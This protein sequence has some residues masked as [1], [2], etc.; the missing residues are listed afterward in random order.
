APLP[1]K[2]AQVDVAKGSIVLSRESRDALDVRTAEVEVR[3]VPD[4]ISAYATLV[5]PWSRH[6][7]ASSRLPGQ[8]AAIHVQAGQQVTGGQVVAEV[9]SLE[10]ENLYLELLNA[11]NDA[12]LA[13]EILKVVTGST[14]AEP[15]IQVVNAKTKVQQTRNALDVAK[16]KWLSLD[17]PMNQLDALLKDGRPPKSPTFPV[18]SPMAGTVIHADLTAGKIVEPGEHLFEIVDLSKVWAKIG[19]LERDLNRVAVGQSVDLRLTAF[20]EKI[21][22]SMVRIKGMALEQPSNLNSVWAEFENAAGNEPTLI[23]GMTGQAHIIQPAVPG[24]KAVPA[25]ALIN[26]GVE[27]YLLIETAN[28]E[29]SSEYLKT[30]VVVVRQTTDWV[31]VHSGGLYPGTRVVTRGSH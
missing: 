12:R 22:H 8:I 3:T 9:R 7:F 21:F 6:A 14:G 11:Q 13:E 25:S 29:Q 16:T 24:N 23:P 1:S 30:P 31:E 19:V 17:L 10:L 20:P 5:A 28:A 4:F 18:R 26:D 15:N 2:G 27:Q